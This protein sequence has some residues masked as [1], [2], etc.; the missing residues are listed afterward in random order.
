VNLG[1]KSEPKWYCGEC[2]EAVVAEARAGHCPSIEPGTGAEEGEKEE[3]KKSKDE[4]EL[5]EREALKAVQI[6]EFECTECHQ[7]FMVD[8]MPNGKHKLHPIREA[9]EE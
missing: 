5:P 7:R 8:H 6:G 1:S 2:A 3:G 9:E 4:E